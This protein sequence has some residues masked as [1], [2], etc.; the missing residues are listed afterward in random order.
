MWGRQRNWIARSTRVRKRACAAP[1]G[2]L[3]PVRSVDGCAGAEAGAGR[4]G[5]A[6][7]RG[8]DSARPSRAPAPVTIPLLRSLS[9]GKQAF[10]D[11]DT[12]RDQR[13]EL[14]I[15]PALQ[16]PCRWRCEKAQA[17]YALVFPDRRCFT[18]MECLSRSTVF[19]ASVGNACNCPAYCPDLR[20]RLTAARPPCV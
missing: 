6:A 4:N 5:L 16:L 17:P 7:Y 2:C 18:C 13:G 11:V 9:T 20:G 15:S 14:S 8:G 10:R 3:V 19:Y 1:S 12:A